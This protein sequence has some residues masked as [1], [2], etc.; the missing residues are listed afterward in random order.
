[1]A[2]HILETLTNEERQ[3]AFELVN[4]QID[5]IEAH[6]DLSQDNI[7]KHEANVEAA[8]AQLEALMT[9]RN[10][11]IEAEIEAHIELQ[12]PVFDEKHAMRQG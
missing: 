6:L 1:M 2:Q 3:T 10:D 5:A 9:Y 8:E 4:S 11:M 7:D 12:S